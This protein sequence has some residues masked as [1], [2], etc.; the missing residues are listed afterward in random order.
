MDGTYPQTKPLRRLTH[1]KQLFSYDL[2]PA[3][4]RFPLE[5][6]RRLVESLFGGKVAKAW[7]TSGLG[8]N[9]FSAP[10]CDK[11]ERKFIRFASGQPSGYL[12]SWP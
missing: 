6:Q 7:V 12:S 11:E 8:V 3:K 1:L 9:V 4:D 2:L 10:A 5:F